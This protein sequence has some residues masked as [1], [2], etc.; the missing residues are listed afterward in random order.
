[1]A[2]ITFRSCILIQTIQQRS[3]Q[4]VGSLLELVEPNVVF[5]F[6]FLF[7]FSILYAKFT[8]GLTKKS[9]PTDSY[10]CPIGSDESKRK[11]LNGFLNLFVEKRHASC[12]WLTYLPNSKFKV[13]RH[14]NKIPTV[15]QQFL[16]NNSVC[17]SSG[18]KDF[19]YM[20]NANFTNLDDKREKLNDLKTR[21]FHAKWW[22]IRSFLFFFFSS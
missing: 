1:M 7:F 15:V 11:S 19:R 10:K 9:I 20:C 8:A 3:F 21:H 16:T 4:F 17:C 18:V 12:G 2:G 13:G 5:N 22:I 6:V 14:K